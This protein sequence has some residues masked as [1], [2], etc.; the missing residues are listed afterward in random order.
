MNFGRKI[1]D[2]ARIGLALPKFSTD[3]AVMTLQVSKS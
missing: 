1:K 2:L 3:D